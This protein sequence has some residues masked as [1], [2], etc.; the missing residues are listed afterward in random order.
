M[1]CFTT[2]ASL[3][4]YLDQ[5]RGGDASVGFVPTMGALHEGHLALVRRSLAENSLTVCSIFVNPIQFN[6]ADDLARY[7]R[8]PESDL[9]MLAKAGCHAVF[10]PSVEEIYPEGETPELPADPGVLDSILEGKFRPGHFRG[11]AIVVKKFFD[12]VMPDTAYFGKKDYQQLAVIK[13]MVRQL[14]I[15][16]RIVPCETVREADGLAMSSRNM[17]LTPAERL[18]APRLFRVLS[19]VRENARILPVDSLKANAVA[20]IES[21]GVF[22]V[23]YFEIADTGTLAP[24]EKLTESKPAV[25]L[26]AAWLG[27]VRLIDNLE[28]FS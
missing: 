26:V 16:V 9:D 15:P 3:R 21:G 8:T 6:R 13:D 5:H 12:L 24:L 20:E 18:A 4:G 19:Q 25:A 1:E 7:P 10:L 14:E 27:E 11:V 23:E 28:L 22:R 17:R 2:A